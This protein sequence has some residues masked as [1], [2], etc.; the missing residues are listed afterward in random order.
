MI[1]S[2]FELIIGDEKKIVKKGDSYHAT[3]NVIHGV[4][5]LEDDSII[6]DAFTPMRADFFEYYFSIK[7]LSIRYINKKVNLSR[8]INNT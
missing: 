6:F 8:D 2:I 4:V 5:A 1:E 7:F 3:K